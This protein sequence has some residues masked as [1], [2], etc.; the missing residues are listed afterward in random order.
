[1]SVRTE[2]FVLPPKNENHHLLLGMPKIRRAPCVAFF[3]SGRLGKMSAPTT[4]C[5]LP[6]RT[7][8]PCL[9]LLL[10]AFGL[11]ALPLCGCTPLGEYVRNGF[12][13]GPNYGKP[14]APAATDWMDA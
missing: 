4:R 1:M 14:P 13:V 10:F 5:G 12:K 8:A 7:L 3:P 11:L 6:Q 9:L 2:E